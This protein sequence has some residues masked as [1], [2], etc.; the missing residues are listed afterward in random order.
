MKSF[1]TIEKSGF[2]FTRL[3]K[4]NIMKV[5][6]KKAREGDSNVPYRARLSKALK[7]AHKLLL[8][9]KLASGARK[10]L[11]VIQARHF[12]GQLVSI[13]KRVDLALQA[14]KR[15]IALSHKFI[16]TQSRQSANLGTNNAYLN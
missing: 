5:A 3:T 2:R 7:V 10:L 14:K 11:N 8:V 1:K 15:K 6:H 16:P 4:S 12:Y 13:A 9:T